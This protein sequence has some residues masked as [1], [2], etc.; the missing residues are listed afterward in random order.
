MPFWLP[1][2]KYKLAIMLMRLVLEGGDSCILLLI[3]EEPH[4]GGHSND[5]IHAYSCASG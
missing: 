1:E 5:A 2:R 3:G 4:Q